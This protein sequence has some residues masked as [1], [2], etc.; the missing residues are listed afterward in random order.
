MNGRSVVLLVGWIEEWQD[1]EGDRF[2][3]LVKGLR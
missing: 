3:R 2:Q 1:C